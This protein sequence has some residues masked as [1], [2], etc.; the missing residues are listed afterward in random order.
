LVEQI[1][2]VVA[3]GLLADPEAL[4][5]VGVGEPLR[6]QRED[7]ALA[8]REIR[9][10]GVVPGWSLETHEVENGLLETAP[11]RLLL[12]KDVVARVELDELRSRDS[13]GRAAPLLDGTDLVVARVDDERGRLDLAEQVGDVDRGPGLEQPR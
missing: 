2:D 13:R 12:E 8:G 6:D 9:E 11:R 1:R 10:R 3:D 5:D 7:L 4:A